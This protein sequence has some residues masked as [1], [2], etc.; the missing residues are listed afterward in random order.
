MGENRSLDEF[1]KES[2]GQHNDGSDPPET[3]IGGDTSEKRP[4]DPNADEA[5]ERAERPGSDGGDRT[6]PDPIATIYR[7]SVGGGVCDACGEGVESRWRSEEAFV[8]GECK[9]W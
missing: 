7:W 3:E 2:G 5:G 4:E 1:L 6:T 9:E 8:C